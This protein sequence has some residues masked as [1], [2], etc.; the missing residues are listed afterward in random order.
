MKK[1]S[2]VENENWLAGDANRALNDSIRYI[3]HQLLELEIDCQL[4]G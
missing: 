2:F 4:C 1:S 3:F